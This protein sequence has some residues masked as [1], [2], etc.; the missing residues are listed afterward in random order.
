[1]LWALLITLLVSKLSGGPEEIF[2]ISG[3]D[4]EIKSHIAD[5]ERRNELLAISKA[6]RKDIKS[7]G[8]I[9][10]NKMKHMD[11]SGLSKDV[12]SEQLFELYNSYHE[13]RLKMQAKLIDKRL[14]I[15]RLLTDIEWKHLIENA[16]LPSEKSRR[17]KSVRK[18]K[19]DHWRYRR[20]H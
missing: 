7:F 9:R 20:D 16:V 14:E 17:K 13:E 18:D 4:K 6:A 5:K 19:K 12:S 1:M 8:E 10:K 11:K 15:Q 3:L 2:L